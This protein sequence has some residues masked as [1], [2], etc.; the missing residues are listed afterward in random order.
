M[1]DPL[2]AVFVI[3]WFF[4]LIC[5]MCAAMIRYLDGDF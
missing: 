1:M 4:I 2:T 3:S 5:F